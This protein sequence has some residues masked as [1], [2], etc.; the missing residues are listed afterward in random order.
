MHQ[1]AIS[2]A[3]IDG[4]VYVELALRLARHPSETEAYLVTRTLAYCLLY[5]EGLC[6]TAGI[7]QGDEPALEMRDP[8]GLRTHWIDVGRPGPSHVQRGLRAAPRMSLVTTR[9]PEAALQAL[10]DADLRLLERLEILGLDGALVDALA[11][12]LDRRNIWSV[13]LTGGHLYVEAD[14]VSLDG[15]V[16]RRQGAS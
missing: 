1:F 14:G 10:R 6:L 4:G 7:C 3:D 12:G 9:D 2:L 16:E 11:R 8:T 5:E 15:A 13:T